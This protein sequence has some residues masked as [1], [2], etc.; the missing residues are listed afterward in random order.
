MTGTGCC[1]DDQP[2]RLSARQRGARAVVGIASLG[3]AGLAAKRVG[4]FGLAAA[5]GAGWFGVSHLV[6]A[7]TGY[8]GCPELGSM[9]SVLLRRDVHVGCVP[10]RI[11]DRRLGLAP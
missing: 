2:E 6:A 3:V 10:W 4:T 11:V 5:T 8:A 1:S 7:R 9:P